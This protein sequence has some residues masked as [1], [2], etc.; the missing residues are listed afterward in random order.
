MMY[1]IAILA[2]CLGVL[3]FPLILHLRARRSPDYDKSNM[4]NTYRIIGFIGTRAAMLSTLSYP[5]GKK[6][7][8]F[9]TKDATEN[10]DMLP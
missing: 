1:L 5:N 3:S 8:N 4:L 9:V 6:P 7:F 2:F 10:V